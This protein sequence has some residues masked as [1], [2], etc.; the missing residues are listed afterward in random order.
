MVQ[1]S[2]GFAVPF[3]EFK[4]QRETLRQWADKKSDT[5]IRQ[6]WQ[7]KNLISIDG[8]PTGLPIYPDENNEK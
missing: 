1:T 5:E 8:N 6:Y 7:E 3:Y 2:C 4:G